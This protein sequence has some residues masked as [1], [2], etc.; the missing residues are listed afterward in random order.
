MILRMTS[1]LR[2]MAPNSEDFCAGWDIWKGQVP[3]TVPYGRRGGGAPD[4]TLFGSLAP[5]GERTPE[6]M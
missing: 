1:T 5:R 3:S 4:V 2:G 6:H